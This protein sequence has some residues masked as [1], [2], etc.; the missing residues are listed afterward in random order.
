MLLG[1]RFEVLAQMVTFLRKMLQYV[2][3]KALMNI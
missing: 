1:F 2:L 3:E